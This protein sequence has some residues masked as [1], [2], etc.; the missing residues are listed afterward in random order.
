VTSNNNLKKTALKSSGM[1]IES[2]TFFV[3]AHITNH[4]ALR[5]TRRAARQGLALCICRTQKA[6]IILAYPS[7]SD[8]EVT[9]MFKLRSK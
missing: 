8:E 1:W 3:M 6:A 5:A 7:Q 9:T 2:V 4:S